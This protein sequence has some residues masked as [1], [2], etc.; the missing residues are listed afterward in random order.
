[1]GVT[2][3]SPL[4]VHAQINNEHFP[5]LFMRYLAKVTGPNGPAGHDLGLVSESTIDTFLINLQNLASSDATVTLGGA[6]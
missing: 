1:M 2:L 6:Q 4:H 5:P 3:K